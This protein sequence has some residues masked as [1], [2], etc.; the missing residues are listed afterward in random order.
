MLTTLHNF[1]ITDGIG[2]TGLVQG[3]D[4]N[5][6]GTTASGGKY[7]PIYCSPYNGCGTVF[8]ATTGGAFTSLHSFQS[9][10]GA[11]LYAPVVQAS[12]GAFYDTTWEGPGG[13]DG[14]IFSIT[15]QGKA[16][17]EYTFRE[18]V[19]IPLS[20]WSKDR[21]V[22]CTAQCQRVIAAERLHLQP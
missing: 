21:T 5:L 2:P 17:T 3:T 16:K 8:K 18:S 6:Y 13:S 14:T 20:D 12:D 7:D 1:N 22:I 11:I 15:S 9:T 19:Q 4:G 10:D